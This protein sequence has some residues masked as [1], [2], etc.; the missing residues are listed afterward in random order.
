MSSIISIRIVLALLVGLGCLLLVLS[1]LEDGGSPHA[2]LQQP[3]V[4]YPDGSPPVPRAGGR[5]REGGIVVRHFEPGDSREIV[6]RS[7]L[8]GAPIEGARLYAELQDGDV[9][10]IGRTDSRGRKDASAV[11]L[12]RAAFCIARADAFQPEIVELHADTREAPLE[13]LMQPAGRIEGTVTYVDGSELDRRVRIVALPPTSRLDARRLRMAAGEHPRY[14]RTETDPVGRFVLEG[15]DPRG[16][17]RLYAG[18]R[19]VAQAGGATVR[20]AARGVLLTVSP[21]YGACVEIESEG[22]GA[23]K[24]HP[25]LRPVD[26]YLTWSQWPSGFLQ[27]DPASA[28]IVVSGASPWPIEEA[29]VYSTGG[30]GVE[31]SYGA[32]PAK[33]RMS[34]FLLGSEG[35]AK[36]RVGPI[37]LRVRVPGYRESRFKV[38]A[39]ST[40]DGR[41]PVQ[42]LRLRRKAESFGHVSVSFRQ[43]THAGSEVVPL[44]GQPAPAGGLVLTNHGTKE[45]LRVAMWQL[46]SK[47][48]TLDGIPSGYYRIELQNT[49]TRE[50]TT[51]IPS[52]VKIGG[53]LTRHVEIDNPATCSLELLHADGSSVGSEVGPYELIV[54]SLRRD[55]TTGRADRTLNFEAGPLVVHGLPRGAWWVEATGDD[56]E[57]EAG[58]KTLFSRKL[59]SLDRPV[60]SARC[61]A[62]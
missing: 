7:A 18:G 28:T 51:G 4:D 26:G 27:L 10:P 17:Y 21:I 57:A 1:L 60:E 37:S 62:W 38:W 35:G 24:T 14:L 19:G 53:G 43:P 36:K 46:P 22:G 50:S 52:L 45:R 15:V 39:Y 20:G 3:I 13:V 23:I 47:R 61:E 25:R 11:V 59:M 54:V 9:L 55:G 42:R 6:C 34:W 32:G 5:G 31:H 33:R 8:D 41:F 29:G 44:P 48:I 16:A 30:L 58:R 49:Y 56:F 12:R 40:N 2:P